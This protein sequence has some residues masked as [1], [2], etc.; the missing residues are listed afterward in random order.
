MINWLIWLTLWTSA[1]ASIAIHVIGPASLRSIYPDGIEGAA[2]LF[3]NVPYG[4][5][6][7]GKLISASSCCS[8]CSTQ[9]FNAT[10]P[11]I[12]VIS[13]GT[14]APDVKVYN[15]QQAGA[16]A[17]LFYSTKTPLSQGDM[18]GSRALSV[19]I[20]SLALNSSV[21]QA[22][23]KTDG[24]I[25]LNITL[26]LGPAQ[27][28]VPLGIA[29]ALTSS[30]D[31]QLLELLPMLSQFEPAKVNYTP[32]YY[33][34]S[35]NTLGRRESSCLFDKK[36]C[37]LDLIDGA[38]VLREVIRQTC[39]Y[40]AS[41]Q[42]NSYAIYINYMNVWFTQCMYNPQSVCT[43]AMGT[44]A[45]RI[46]ACYNKSFEY[47][48]NSTKPTDNSILR[49]LQKSF[50]DLRVPMIPAAVVGQEMVF[51]ELNVENWKRAMCAQGKDLS[52]CE[53]YLCAQGCWVDMLENG[54]CDL[55]CN[56]KECAFDK[57]ACVNPLILPLK[58]S[59]PQGG[60]NSTSS[61]TNST[62]TNPPSNSTTLTDP[63][64]STNSTF[65]QNTT[66]SN[67]TNSTSSPQPTNTTTPNPAPTWQCSPG[68]TISVF[69][70][71]TCQPAC[72][73]SSCEY[74]NWTCACTRG[75]SP[76]LLENDL[77]DNV[78]NNP[79]CNY[80]AGVCLRTSVPFPYFVEGENSNGGGDS[81]SQK[82]IIIG[83]SLFAFV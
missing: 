4:S 12:F 48:T 38:A 74:Q 64:P 75:C 25:Y 16:K 35:D 3:G 45:A 65:P 37:S 72:N 31:A 57:N 18:N 19:S 24:D 49:A 13:Y 67:P 23:V 79:N 70:S 7:A 41:V 78:C 1:F 60:S 20:P 73:V 77:C 43:S 29:F 58:T 55:V 32:Y 59:N 28:P 33:I 61:S 56:V 8:S 82:W 44:S 81:S 2:A 21:Y 34:F 26:D 68:C 14:C 80:D 10:I 17:V 9:D 51:G 47:A 15:A 52:G 63:L 69:A 71:A 5:Y 66:S 27:V 40:E 39:A 36:Y 54:L 76:T 50:F 30:L 11:S 62:S 46:Q 42:D 53:K 83:C 22:L 6:A